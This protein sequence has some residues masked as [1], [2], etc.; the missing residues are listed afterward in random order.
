MISANALKLICPNADAKIV[1]A[2]VDH[3]AEVFAKRN[4]Q[5][6]EE[7]CQLIAQ[8][9]VETWGLTRF[10]ENLNYSGS[11]LWQVFGTSH[12]KSEIDAAH[13]AADGPQA[14][15]NRVYGGRMGNSGS[16]DGWT[17]RARGPLGLTG[18]DQYAAMERAT[19][20]PLVANPDLA[21]SEAHAL[22]IA[23]AYWTSRNIHEP[24]RAG[25]TAEVTR[26]ING[27]SNGLSDRIMYL[28]RAHHYLDGAEPATA[29]VPAPVAPQ[30]PSAITAPVA[31]S[32][33]TLIQRLGPA[34]PIEPLLPVPAVIPPPPSPPAAPVDNDLI[35]ETT[36]ALLA[37]GHTLAEAFAAV[38][39]MLSAARKAS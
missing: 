14:I 35:H 13:V 9:C 32:A 12:F 2:I 17:F 39:A 34:A 29:T 26:L 21:L 31:P 36:R 15:A 37:A 18:H 30:A 23:C 19:G 22:D 6:G 10:E 28:G 20:L 33:G 5:P 1:A 25:K 8:I 38:V 3:A 4:I 11:R 7:A 24:A 16:N 27:G